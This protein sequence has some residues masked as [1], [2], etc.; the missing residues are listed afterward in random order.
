MSDEIAQV[1]ALANQKGGVGKTTLTVNLAAVTVK[2]LIKNKLVV[3]YDPGADLISP[4]LVVSTDPQASSVWWSDRASQVNKLPFDYMQVTDPSQLAD[5]CQEPGRRHIFVDTP[6]SLED[7]AILQ[8]VLDNA[9]DVLVPMLPE[10]LSFD[11]TTRTIEQVLAPRGIPY[12]VVV[13][14][15]EPRDGETDLAQTA[16]YIVKQGW[17][18]ANTVIRRYKVH[19][20]AAAEGRVCTD[21]AKSRTSDQALQ[22]FLYLALELGYGGP[23]AV[24]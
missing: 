14:G 5:L 22:D 13:N 9:D 4:V 24:A 3:G 20:R 12:T 10:A 18:M 7:E 17:P 2:A 19:T 1:H 6:G 8:A 21:Y 15:H 11:P 23:G 16:Q